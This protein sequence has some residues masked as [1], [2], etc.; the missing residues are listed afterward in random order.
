MF[1]NIYNLTSLDLLSFDTSLVTN[2]N[3]MFLNCSN[4]ISLNLSSFNTEGVFGMKRMFCNCSNLQLLD[5]SNFN[6]KYVYIVDIF[7]GIYKN[8]TI[9]TKDTRICDV[10]PLGSKCYSK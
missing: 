1:K 7:E 5:L 6:T 3:S 2:M 8:M 4:L 10:K 9:I